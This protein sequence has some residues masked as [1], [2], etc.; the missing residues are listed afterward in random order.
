MIRLSFK[1]WDEQRDLYWARKRIWWK[2][3]W[4]PFVRVERARWKVADK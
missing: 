2:G 4:T 3:W 1:T